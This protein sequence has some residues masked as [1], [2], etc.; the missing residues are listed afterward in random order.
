MTRPVSPPAPS[1]AP[2]STGEIAQVLRGLRHSMLAT[3]SFSFLLSLL[4]LVPS[5]YMMQVYD[6]VLG[7]RNEMT[8][9]MLTLLAAGLYGIYAALEYS[10][11]AVLQQ[12]SHAIDHKLSS[13]VFEAAF[14]DVARSRGGNPSAAMNDLTTLRQFISGTGLILLFD[15]PF[16]LVFMVA[17]FMIDFWLGMFLIGAC[18]VLLVLLWWS[19]RRTHGPL[20]EANRLNARANSYMNN[21]FRNAEVIQAMGM[22]PAVQRRWQLMGEQA[23]DLQAETS[24]AAARIGAVTKFVRILSQ[25]LSLGLGALLVLEGRMSGGMMIAASILLG[26]ALSPLEMLISGWRQIVA[27]RDAH[28]RLEQLLAVVPPAEPRMP[29]PAPKG[30]LS[31]EQASV[32]APGSQTALLRQL[33]FSAEPGEVLTIIGPSGAGKSTAARLLAG[34]WAPQVGKV[35]LDGADLATW[36]REEL[37]PHIGFLP[38]DVE[39]FEGTVAENIARLAEPDSIEVVAAAQAAGIHDMV[40]RL[41]QGYD[42]PVGPGGAA[43]SGGQ[44]QR[45]GLARALYGRPQL[46]ILDEPNANLDDL[47]EAALAQ[48][49]QAC[50]AR[51][52][53]VVVISHRTALLRLTDKL[54]LLR[55][56]QLAAFGPRDKVMQSL[57]AQAAP[58]APAA[59]AAPGAVAVAAAAPT[60]APGASGPAPTRQGSPV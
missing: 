34:V 6:R 52:A 17:G 55:D 57:N 49:L 20:Q 53:T 19:E 28:T 59:Q 16:A 11:S 56:G 32:A 8:L 27:A 47:G 41:P 4:L 51:G 1:A 38:Q 44:R 12:V 58:A 33:S 26:R 29:L 31:V 36:P 22:L 5:L 23:L 7:S 18:I 14:S 15:G 2:A 42:T 50:K 48:A 13:R 24:A 60:A 9:L 54:L 43:L 39:L 30:K 46:L 3:G 25:S 37:A 40:L 35:R 21:S 10:R 45:V